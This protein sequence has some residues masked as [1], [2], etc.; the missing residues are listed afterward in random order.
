MRIT[1]DDHS[2]FCFGVIHAIEAAER[3]LQD[4]DTLYCLGDIVHNNEEVARL[5][6]NGL[7]VITYEQFEQLHNTTVLIRAHGE[8]PR[9]YEIARQNNITLIDATCPVVL[10]LQQTIYDFHQHHQNQNSQ[11]LIFG[12]KGHAEVIGLLGQVEGQGIVISSEE[13]LDRIDYSRP[14]MLY[15]QTTQS[16]EHYYH[17]I[18][19]I[20]ERYEAAGNGHLF[21]YKDTICRKVANRATQTADFASQHDIILFVSDEK[22][23]NGMYLFHICQQHNPNSHFITHP[24]QLKS[25]DFSLAESVGICG[26]TSTPR[27]LMEECAQYCKEL[28]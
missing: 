20:K 26:A 28:I 1:I 14:A 5:T 4:H 15:S 19:T 17:L 9:T 18:Q 10:K 3:Y 23:S 24:E 21:Q 25:I 16:L 2:G 7:R 8:P 11:I 27:W 22:S 12:K 6:D 13:E